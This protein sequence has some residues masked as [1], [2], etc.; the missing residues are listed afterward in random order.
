MSAL[1]VA[2]VIVARYSIIAEVALHRHQIVPIWRRRYPADQLSAHLDEVIPT[3]NHK[4]QLAIL[5]RDEF[6]ALSQ[7]KL[8]QE[9]QPQEVTSICSRVTLSTPD[10]DTAH[11]PIMNFTTGKAVTCQNIELMMHAVCG[12]REGVLLES[13]R[14]YHYYGNFLLTNEQWIRFMAICLLHSPLV[15]ADY[16]A[17]RLLGGMAML[18]LTTCPPLKPNIPVVIQSVRGQHSG[19]I[20]SW[21]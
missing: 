16:I 21:S 15:S 5:R 12:A 20:D 19:L 7:A 14:S 10:R 4:P 8:A 6:L 11:L 1:E 13:G 3:A 9:Q 18:R 2:Q 17:Y